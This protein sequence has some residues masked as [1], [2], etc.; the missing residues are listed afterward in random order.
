M[1]LWTPHERRRLKTIIVTGFA[2]GDGGVTEHGFK[3]GL[4]LFPPIRVK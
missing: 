3:P 4:H 2:Y 1:R